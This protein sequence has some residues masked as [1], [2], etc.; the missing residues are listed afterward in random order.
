AFLVYR[1]IR[2]KLIALSQQ[3]PLLARLQYVVHA[4]TVELFRPADGFRIILPDPAQS[5]RQDRATV[6]RIVPFASDYELALV[7]RVLERGKDFLVAEKP[8]ARVD[9]LILAAV[10]HEDA[11]RFGLGLADQG[12]QRVAA[13]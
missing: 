10:L 6:F 9:I 13:A 1:R 3:F 8:I 4:A 12:R 2:A 5:V 7:A 11:Q